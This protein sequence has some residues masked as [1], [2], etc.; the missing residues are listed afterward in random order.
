MKGFY[1]SFGASKERS[2]VP[3]TGI[4]QLCIYSKVR[5][6]P[7]RKQAVEKDPSKIIRHL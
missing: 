7:D 1:S 4:L 3:K 2:G 6:R 5:L